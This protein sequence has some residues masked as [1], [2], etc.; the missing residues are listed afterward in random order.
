MSVASGV[1]P[2]QFFAG[3]TGSSQGSGTKALTFKGQPGNAVRQ[4][5]FRSPNLVFDGINVDAQMAMLG[6]SDGALFEN[7][8][9]PFTF[10]N[11]SIGNVADQKGALVDGRGIVFDNVLFHDVVLKTSGVHTEC[12][13]LEVPEG[14]IIRNSTFRNCAV[15]DVFFKYP[16][17]GPAPAR[18]MGT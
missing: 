18:P 2:T 10:K 17:C 11:G 5:H 1:Y 4:I 15:M 9:A 13:Y 7:G 8:G 3:G 6:G 14:M 12:A 16:D